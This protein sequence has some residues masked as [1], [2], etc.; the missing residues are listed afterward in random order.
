MYETLEQYLDA[1]FER[2]PRGNIQPSGTCNMQRITRDYINYEALYYNVG[3]LNVPLLVIHDGITSIP[4]YAFWGRTDVESIKIPDSVTSIG[5]ESFKGCTGLKSLIIPDSVTS[6]GDRAFYG[7][8]NLPSM[9]I[10]ASVTSVGKDVFGSGC[11]NIKSTVITRTIVTTRKA[12]SKDDSYFDSV[13][14]AMNISND[15]M[16]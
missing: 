15:D 12:I 8:S 16:V 4:D 3:T 5:V 9:T 6:I 13:F 11:K 7:C 2:Y 14:D 1:V 10:P